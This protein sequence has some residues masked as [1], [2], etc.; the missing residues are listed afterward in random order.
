MKSNGL[1]AFTVLGMAVGFLGAGA[2][3][4][5]EVP[6]TQEEKPTDGDVRK[7][8][9]LE[10]TTTD[11]A[12]PGAGV[13]PEIGGNA[14]RSERVSVGG[15][16]SS[17]KDDY[18]SGSGMTVEITGGNELELPPLPPRV[19]ILELLN[20]QAPIGSGSSWESKAL[21][22]FDFA[23]IGIKVTASGPVECRVSWRWTDDEEFIADA[24][25]VATKS[26]GLPRMA[27]GDVHGTQALI[28]CE[29]ALPTD[30]WAVKVLLR[31]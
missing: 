15:G 1:I 6:L 11:L 18:G 30:L 23:R 27:F 21:D 28:A 20:R 5:P 24:P 26:D 13:A 2:Q 3:E 4:P 29:A 14:F 9:I 12:Q 10:A 31:R 8:P 16:V 25:R 7:Q 17:W 19:E 22:T